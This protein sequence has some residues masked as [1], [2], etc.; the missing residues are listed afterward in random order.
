VSDGHGFSVD[1][2]AHGD[3][4]DDSNL[5]AVGVGAALAFMRIMSS[6]LFEVN[7]LD[8]PTYVAGAVMLLGAAV[9]ASYLP[10]R[11]ALA[12]NPID[13]LRAE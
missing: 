2:L 10:A 9:L 5:L 8:P 4:P 3:K 12:A 11:R 7:P 6:L 1:L 13:A